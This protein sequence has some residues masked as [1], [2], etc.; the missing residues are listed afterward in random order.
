MAASFERSVFGISSTTEGHVNGFPEKSGKRP[1]CGI[2][3]SPKSRQK[4]PHLYNLMK[5]PQVSIG[6]ACITARY[7]AKFLGIRAET[8]S[9]VLESRQKQPLLYL[10]PGRYDSDSA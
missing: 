1:L 6:G 9:V 3:D 5:K 2:E 4:A 10:S 7:S 8:T